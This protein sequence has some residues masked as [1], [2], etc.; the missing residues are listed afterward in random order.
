MY[1]SESSQVDRFPL[2]RVLVLL[3]AGAFSGLMVDI[4]V[5]HVDVVREHSI[6]WVP[7]IYSGFMTIAC[8]AAFIFWNRTAR[9][10]M[11]PLFFLAFVVGGIGFYLHNH[12]HLLRVMQTQMQ[13]WTDPGMNHPDTPPQT[14]PLAFMGLGGIGI[15]CSLRRFDA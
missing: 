9:R 2:A 6:A 5:E 3:L 7:I 4:R 15:L 12:G 8:L 11:V 10:V 1:T 14:A 13:A